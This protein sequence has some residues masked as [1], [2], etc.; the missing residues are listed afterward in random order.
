MIWHIFLNNSVSPG[1]SW[2]SGVR[3]LKKC[4][5]FLFH[6]GGLNPRPYLSWIPWELQGQATWNHDTRMDHLPR[7]DF[8]CTLP[9]MVQS[10]IM[11]IQWP[12][13]FY[14]TMWGPRLVVDT[15]CRL[16]CLCLF[17]M[18]TFKRRRLFGVLPIFKMPETKRLRQLFGILPIL[19]QNARCGM[20]YR[21]KPTQ[22][23]SIIVFYTYGWQHES[24]N[25]FVYH[26]LFF[27]LHSYI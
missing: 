10:I 19:N 3:V 12:E 18:F 1:E 5:V 24:H 16:A 26:S 9:P 2:D 17:K 8:W 14:S 22:K 4:I 25:L 13:Y 20:T 23:C 27:S 6:K 11:H 21:F 7:D 15:S